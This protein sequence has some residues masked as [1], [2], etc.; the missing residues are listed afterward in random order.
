MLFEHLPAQYKKIVLVE[1]RFIS[2]V[3]MNELYKHNV[4]LILVSAD[5]TYP[6]HAQT[7]KRVW[8]CIQNDPEIQIVVLSRTSMKHLK[9]MEY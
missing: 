2:E 6:R 8:E 5:K 4:E 9:H 1:N 3:Y 7:R